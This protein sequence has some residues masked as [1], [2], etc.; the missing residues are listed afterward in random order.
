M[1]CTGG[2]MTAGMER[3]ESMKKKYVYPGVYCESFELSHHIA[4]C[5]GVIVKMNSLNLETCGGTINDKDDPLNGMTFFAA[6][7]FCGSDNDAGD[8][9]VDVEGYCYTKQDNIVGFFG[10]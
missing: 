2:P 6:D 4:A 10:S 5:D 7:G 3:G 1:M 8:K 9:F